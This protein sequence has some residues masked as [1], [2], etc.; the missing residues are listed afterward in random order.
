MIVA[1]LE[2]ERER[3]KKNNGDEEVGEEIRERNERRGGGGA[4][5][6]K[7]R[8]AARVNSTR[9]E[10]HALAFAGTSEDVPDFPSCVRPSNKIA[11]WRKDRLFG[12]GNG[13]R[14]EEEEEEVGGE[15]RTMERK[16][17]HPE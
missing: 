7:M 4:R 10:T 13:N 2:R 5:L 1:P 14:E 8:D 6:V 12:G 3:E 16:C 9:L 17:S 15:A 11:S